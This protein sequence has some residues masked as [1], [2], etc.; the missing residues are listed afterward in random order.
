MDT[1]SYNLIFLDT[2]TTGLESQ[3]KIC[4]IS[5]SYVEKPKV[6][7]GESF[8]RKAQRITYS[9]LVNPNISISPEASMITG[10]TNSQVKEKPLFKKTKSYAKL[11][12]LS[13]KENSF[14][15]AY[16][17]QFDI[18]ML[19]KD[20]LFFDHEKVIDLY[21]VAKHL[22]KDTNVITSKGENV[23][24]SNKKLQYFR[25]LLDFDSQNTF[26]SLSNEYGLGFLKP[27]SSLS[28]VLVLEYFFYYILDTFSLSFEELVELSKKPVFENK[29]S[30]GNVFDKGTP[31]D[32]CLTSSYTQY[33]KVKK[34]YDYI[35]WCS[36]NL[37]LSLDVDY[38]IKIHFFNH[39]IDKSIPYSEKFLK[40]INFGL[41]FEDSEEKIEKALSLIKKDNYYLC[42][43]K[44]KF[45]E[46]LE[47][48]YSIESSDS[49][50]SLSNKLSALFLLRYLES[51]KPEVLPTKL[52]LKPFSLDFEKFVNCRFSEVH[53]GNV[54]VKFTFSL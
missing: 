40:Y 28:D 38:S 46:K 30:F 53:L 33:D 4:E 13:K 45:T 25:Y 50:Y 12:N 29:I 3:D 23:P 15:I 10:L 47:K 43:L 7:Y 17:S 8:F 32:D 16:N 36:S 14:F 6:N 52:C 9:E 20:D 35:N 39:L 41:V 42:F 34:G 19:E 2:E 44:F 1:S 22:Y 18:D 31:F 11:L 51:L 54:L 26:S 24:L 49:E 48:T 5:F 27:H 37:E 21:R